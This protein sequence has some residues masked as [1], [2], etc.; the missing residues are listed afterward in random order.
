MILVKQLLVRGKRIER[1][2]G[3]VWV[4]GGER[5]RGEL[6]INPRTRKAVP[7]R[8]NCGGDGRGCPKTTRNAAWRRVELELWC[9]IE[10]NRGQ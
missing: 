6:T 4:C 9:T 10:G 8:C 5:M 2:V 3:V 7:S 1:V